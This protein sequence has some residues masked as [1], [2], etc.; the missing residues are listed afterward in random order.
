M[1]KCNGMERNSMLDVRVKPARSGMDRQPNSLTNNVVTLG[2]EPGPQA[3]AS[4][5]TLGR[6]PKIIIIISDTLLHNYVIIIPDEHLQ[7]PRTL[8]V[9]ILLFNYDCY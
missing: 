8:L 9:K 7:E 1:G 3:S 6:P 2:I 4:T 5:T